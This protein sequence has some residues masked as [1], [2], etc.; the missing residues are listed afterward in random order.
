MC[1]LK[2]GKSNQSINYMG[3]QAAY[4]GKTFDCDEWQNGSSGLYSR[5]FRF[6]S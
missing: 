1:T 3:D 4:R 5:F 2:Y 6:F